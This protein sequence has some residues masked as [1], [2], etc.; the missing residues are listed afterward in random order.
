MMR[1][2]QVSKSYKDNKVLQ[3]ISFVVEK[4]HF[5][6][7]IGPSGCG[8]TTMLK[9]INKL[10]K[11]TSGK[12]FINGEDIDFK[13]TIELRRSM[14]YVIQSTGLFP[15][16]T[17]QENIELIP[18]LTRLPP[19]AITQ[20]SAEL[21][22]V[23]GLNPAIYLNRYP[24]QLSGGQQQRIGVVRALATDPEI[25]LMDEPFSSLDPI[26]RVQLQDELASL[27]VKLK[28]TFV[29]VTHDMSEAI[30][31]ADKICIMNQGVVVQYDVPEQIIKYPV[32]DFVRN[33][34]G[35]QRIW[36]VPELIRA[37][38]IM[39]QSITG[40]SI[41]SMVK[42]LELM[43]NASVDSLLI[44]DEG[45]ALKGVVYAR[46][47]LDRSDPAGIAKDVLT[48]ISCTVTS[49][50]NIVQVLKTM[51]SNEITSVPVVAEDGRL[52]GIITRSSLV[53]TLGSQYIEKEE[54]G[55]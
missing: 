11:P 32:D 4:G 49:L 20:K 24:T 38:D 50:D 51:Q 36:S 16:L 43:R 31:L 53:T 6:V 47:I 48:P 17:I 52:V 8:K 30:K 1:F 25:V 12:I 13:N 9:M 10:I 18:K 41:F 19:K 45:G 7:F 40:L 2:E 42:C 28:K 54:W 34:V 29:F 15:H 55:I 5:V 37:K 21:M 22:D 27:Q 39:V 23:V 14:G 35:K 46:D 44:V 3:N 33:F 26:T